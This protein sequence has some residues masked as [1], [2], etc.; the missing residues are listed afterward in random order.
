MQIPLNDNSESIPANTPQTDDAREYSS[1][2]TQSVYQ[3]TPN[4]RRDDEDSRTDDHISATLESTSNDIGAGADLFGDVLFSYS[5]INTYFNH[6]P[7]QKLVHYKLFS[8]TKQ[9]H[10]QLT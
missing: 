5:T 3:S 6:V 9:K 10:H 2:H 7:S 4:E 8:I 1:D